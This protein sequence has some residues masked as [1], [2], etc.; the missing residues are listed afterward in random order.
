MSDNGS[1]KIEHTVLITFKIGAYEDTVECDVVPMTVC[2]MLLGRPWQFDKGACHDGRT[3]IYNFKWKDKNFVLRPMSP[4]QI[5]ADN[6]KTLARTQEE[7]KQRE[8]SGERATHL[9]VSESQKPNKSVN[10]KSVLLATKRE[11][12]EL[13]ENP[14]INHYVLICKGTADETNDLS[15]IPPSLMFV[16][17]DFK[18]VFPNELPP[19]LPPLRGIEHRID[20]IPGAPLP[21]RAAYRT[22]PEETKE[23]E[24]Q[25]QDLLSKGYV[26]ESLSP[27]AV[28]VILI[29]KAD[30]TLRLCMDCHPINAITVRYRHPIPRLDDMLD[31]LSG[32]CIF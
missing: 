28:P 4:S 27:C 22:N 7:A 17:K 21:D 31:E 5:I 10:L 2:H 23:I 26:R 29:P 15:T 6:A 12:R 13:H 30:N 1:V 9:H 19:G 18:D 14:S 32:S 25:I 16:L 20:L 8:L 24:R 3:N 11:M